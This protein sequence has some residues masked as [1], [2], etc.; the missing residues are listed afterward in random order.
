MKA[1]AFADLPVHAGRR[2]VISLHAIDAEIVL[3]VGRA[4]GIDKAER[5]KVAAVLGP[6]LDEWNLFKVDLLLLCFENRP[7]RDAFCSELA[8][9]NAKIAI[10]P[11]LAR[12]LAE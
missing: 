7:E 5:V 12:A 9:R 4:L 2:A 11:K 8:S 10:F 1:A 3:F 6:E